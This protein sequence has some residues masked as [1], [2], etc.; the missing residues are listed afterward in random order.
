[1]CNAEWELRIYWL[2]TS[3]ESSI[4]GVIGHLALLYAFFKAGMLFFSWVD[5]LAYV[6]RDCFP[7]DSTQR[8]HL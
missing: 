8:Q 7:P 6:R 4:A 3:I 5:A 1:M 2:K